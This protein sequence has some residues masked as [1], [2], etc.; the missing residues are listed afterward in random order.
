MEDNMNAVNIETP[1][2]SHLILVLWDSGIVVIME[3]CLLIM[4]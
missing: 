2:C 4:H 1:L 3:V